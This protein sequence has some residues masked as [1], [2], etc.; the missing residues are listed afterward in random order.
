MQPSVPSVRLEAAIQV[1]GLHKTWGGLLGRGGQPALAG[2]DLVIP[3]GAAF[4][5]I[6]PNGAGKTTLIKTLLGIARPTSGDVTVLGG[7]PED[8]AIR[9]RMGYLPE[10]LELPPAWTPPEFLRSVARLKSLENPG[11]G[12]DALLARVG[13]ST[14][15]H[16]KVGGFS[17][18]MK[19][20]L[21]L[22][23]AMLGQPE[24]LVLDEPTDGVDPVG[25]MEIRALLAEERAR[26]ATLLLN[27]HLLAETERVCDR[28]GVL[29]KGK[30]V[31]E[32]TLEELSRPSRGYRVK[33]AGVLS[34][35]SLAA[36]GLVPVDGQAG[37]FRFEALD[38]EALN[39]VLDAVRRD[40]ALLLELQPE[41]RD[42]EAVL[43]AALEEV[44]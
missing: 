26:G 17:K 20:R 35:E 18:G 29:S 2:V 40:G 7:S 16:R 37:S 32:G 14:V 3:R 6:G 42:L 31:Q 5:L 36:R 41:A 15:R 4:G 38:A 43:T 22:A 23:A 39:R 27:S 44:A 1:R 19:Q 12:I 21:G 30:L 24:L 13:L 11:P 10:R 33:L 9:R 34:V 25:R 28:I 8:P